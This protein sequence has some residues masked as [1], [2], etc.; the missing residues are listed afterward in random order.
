MELGCCGVSD[1]TLYETHMSQSPSEIKRL[2]EV[3]Q[4]ENVRRYLEI[5]SR[6]GGSLWYIGNEL[7]PGSRIVS[8]DSGVQMVGGAKNKAGARV[9]LPACIDA[10]RAN[11][12]DAHLI[13]GDS[14]DSQTVS[15]V[16]ALGPYDAVLIDGGHDWNTISAD[17]ENYG[18]MAR[19]VA[20]HDIAWVKPQTKGY[21]AQ[22]DVPRLWSK[23]R[24][25]Y[26]CVQFI[27]PHWNMGIGV[28]W[29]E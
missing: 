22:V 26:R 15:E 24:S 7:P 17:W 12:Y 18:P 13:W 27:D 2:I 11:G 28:L 4:Q 20:F 9:S 21:C 10:L 8:V 3:F 19:I 5:G 25:R 14:T 16:D 6:W 1:E 29:R 23:L